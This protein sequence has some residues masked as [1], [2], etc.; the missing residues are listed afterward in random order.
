VTGL[1]WVSRS[2]QKGAE[3]PVRYGPVGEGGN[4]RGDYALDTGL[5]GGHLFKLKGKLICARPRPGCPGGMRGTGTRGAWLLATPGGALA[6]APKGEAARGSPIPPGCEAAALR[7][8][9]RPGRTGEIG[10]ARPDCRQGP[11]SHSKA[12]ARLLR[13][14]DRPKAS[15]ARRAWQGPGGMPAARLACQ[16]CIKTRSTMAR[17]RPG[18]EADRERIPSDGGTSGPR[19]ALIRPCSS[20]R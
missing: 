2:W 15:V 4:I 11:L 7:W 16:R 19:R 18:W 20:Y 17:G 12:A 14:P 13:R 5:T 3:F 8:S 6:Q 9:G 10:H 1:A